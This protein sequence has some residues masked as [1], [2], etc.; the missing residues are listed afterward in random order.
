[1]LLKDMINIMINIIENQISAGLEELVKPGA[2]SEECWL[3]TIVYSLSTTLD[4]KIEF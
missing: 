2:T 4:G 3:S 1:M